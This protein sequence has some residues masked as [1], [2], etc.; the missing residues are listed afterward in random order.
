M[1]TTH[2][3][4]IKEGKATEGKIM[5]YKNMISEGIRIIVN[6]RK[7]KSHYISLH[8][9]EQDPFW[10]EHYR[11]RVLIFD[12]EIKYWTKKNDEFTNEIK[13]LDAPFYN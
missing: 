7:V 11:L 3:K 5:F 13:D 1:E 9:S 8:K 2:I 10:K 4:L 12:Q 6:F